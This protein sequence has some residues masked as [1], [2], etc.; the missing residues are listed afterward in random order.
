MVALR[1][2]RSGGLWAPS[3]VAS[4]RNRSQGEKPVSVQLSDKKMDGNQDGNQLGRGMEQHGDLIDGT[5]A[6]GENA[7]TK[8]VSLE[9]CASWKHRNLFKLRQIPMLFRD[10]TTERPSQGKTASVLQCDHTAATW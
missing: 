4:G 7:R 9:R 5:G 3:P 10:L 1:A 2:D 8:P 6:N